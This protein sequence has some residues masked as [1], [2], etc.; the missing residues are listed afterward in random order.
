[1][2]LSARR[3]AKCRGNCGPPLPRADAGGTQLP[4]PRDL[5]P[6]ANAGPEIASAARRESTG[7]TAFSPVPLRRIAASFASSIRAFKLKAHLQPCAIILKASKAVGEIQNV[8]RD[9]LLCLHRGF[10]ALALRKH[11]KPLGTHLPA[12]FLCQGAYI[13]RLFVCLLRLSP[14]IRKAFME[15]V[16]DSLFSC[17]HSQISRSVLRLRLKRRSRFFSPFPIIIFHRRSVFRLFR[18]SNS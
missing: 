11:K 17:S 18:A 6:L 10:R 4:Q 15:S 8:G 2:T 5:R 13:Q 14:S 1:M 3:A 16:C 9:L 12:E 7:E